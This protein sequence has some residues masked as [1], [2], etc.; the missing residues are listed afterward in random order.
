M[1]SLRN[2]EL[3]RSANR[4]VLDAS[5]ILA[6]I[7]DEPG[8]DVVQDAPE[9]GCLISSV[10]IAEAVSILVDRGYGDTEIGT[11]LRISNLEIAPLE[12]GVAV[13]AGIL[14]RSTRSAGLSIGDRFCIALAQTLGLPAVTAPG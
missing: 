6:L 1:I 10:N 9:G 8:Y 4:F 12:P 11:M 14:R 3:G 5:A 7:L 13:V 2:G